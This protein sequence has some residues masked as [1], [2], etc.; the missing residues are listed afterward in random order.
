MEII[1]LNYLLGYPVQR[2]KNE[3][4]KRN[5]VEL[6]ASKIILMVDRVHSFGDELPD[7]KE[8]CEAESSGSEAVNLFCEWR[9]DVENIL[10]ERSQKIQGFMGL[11][12]NCCRRF[13]S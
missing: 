4:N 2:I 3:K 1:R 7:F 13:E 10:K 6:L 8:Y 11:I 12:I 9:D 5:A